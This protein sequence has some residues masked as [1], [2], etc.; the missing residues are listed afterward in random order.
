MEE[1]SGELEIQL[2]SMT[3]MEMA[4]QYDQLIQL[5]AEIE[6]KYKAFRVAL[7]EATKKH[8]VIS[9]KTERYTIT[10]QTRNTIK[11]TDH[12]TAIRELED[13]NIPVQTKV[14]LDDEYMKPVY[15]E[16]VKGGEFIPGIES[17]QTEFVTV[18]PTKR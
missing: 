15:E 18:R 5:K 3:P 6:V 17:F 11:V 16:L 10:R 13:R 4:E 7:L 2:S 12:Q 1:K 8:G 9:L 14:V